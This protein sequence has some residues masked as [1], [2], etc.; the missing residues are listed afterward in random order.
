MKRFNLLLLLSVILSTHQANATGGKSKWDYVVTIS[1]SMGEMKVILYEETPQHRENF[2]KL[3]EQ[4]FYDSLAF[5]RVI[6]DFMVQGGDPK[7][8]LGAGKSDIGTDGPGYTIPAE[9]RPQYFHHKGALAAA[10]MGDLANPHKA[11]SG[12]QFYLVQGKPIKEDQLVPLNSLVLNNVMRKIKRGTPLSDTLAFAMQSGREAFLQKLV[13]L[14]DEVEKLTGFKVVPPQERIDVYTAIG[15]TPF[16][17]DQYTV[18]G[19]VMVGLEVIDKIAAVET[20]ARDRPVEPVWMYISA[21]RLKKKK[22]TKLY[23]YSYE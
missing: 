7:S 19:E 16:L 17:D 6:K 14:K 8:R 21:K 12:S 3:I 23:G 20:A 9:F 11:S 22:I 18:F 1:T 13:D 5:H 2:L 4:G 10:R 15:G